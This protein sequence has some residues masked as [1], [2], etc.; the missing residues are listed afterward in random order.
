MKCPVDRTTLV[1]S[2]RSGVEIDY[3]PQRRGVWQVRG[4]FDK[5]VE[6][7]PPPVLLQELPRDYHEETRRDFGRGSEGERKKRRKSLLGDIFDF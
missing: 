3:C 7:A 6:R 4:E 1:M 2:G 5:F